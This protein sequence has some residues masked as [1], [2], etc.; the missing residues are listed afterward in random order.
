MRR[1]LGIIR[2]GAVAGAFVL[3]ACGGEAPA[4]VAPPP[5]PAASASASASPPSAPDALGPKP[6]VPSPP[7]FT[8]PAPQVFASTN[9]I[10]VWL[11]ERHDVPLVSCDI[12]V[13]SGASSDPKGK[14]GL[15]YVTTNMLDEGAGT[16]GAL[17]L[18]R[19][20]DDLGARIGTGSD[21]DSSTVSLTV[22]K[23]NLDK[24]FALFGDVVARPRFEAREW[25]RVKDL[26]A[27]E[28]RERDKDPE[29]TARVV[30]RVAY[31]GPDHPYGHP[32][33]GTVPS[34]KAIS[35]E[36]AK[37]FYQASW[38]PDRAT[39]VCV[40]DV[41]KAELQPLVDAAF[42]TWKAP[43]TPAPAPL[44]PAAPTGPWPKVILVDRPDAPQSVIAAVR[45]GL[46]ASNPDEPVLWRDNEIIGGSFTSRLNAD[47]RESKGYTYG[48]GTRYSR[49]RG[50][51]LLI[52]S[53]AVRTDVTGDALGALLSDMKTFA[54]QGL[55][56]EEVARS[57]SLPRGE[58]VNVYQSD[59]GIAG[60][61]SRFAS[62]GLPPDW[63]AKSSQ[64][65]DAA[66]KDDL[67]RLARQYYSVDD[68]IIVVV[69]PRSRVQSQ[70]DKLGL[71]SAEL[72]DAAGN[73]VK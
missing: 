34:S 36:D 23:R 3:G 17:D 27:N 47:L 30:Y 40:G 11:M 19:A 71:P 15:A 37:S 64:I 6:D 21:A 14:A 12:D 59:E 72:R 22:L 9:G 32:W 2:S 28:L 48:A 56:D 31:F 61:L 57:K 35:L 33:D 29:A 46:A 44:V 13:P 66:T 24:G 69:G 4:P 53:A 20:I 67:N 65:R 55:T 43:A 7:P 50:V 18:A 10:T 38:R 62:V 39:L 60:D 51:G 8:P 45:T 25:K 68:A 52:A 58:V 1:N 63:E 26:W 54:A 42:K 41:T 70:L 16:R 5:M 49:S 73:V